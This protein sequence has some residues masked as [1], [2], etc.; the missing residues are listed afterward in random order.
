VALITSEDEFTYFF[1]CFQ[2]YSLFFPTT[3]LFRMNSVSSLLDLP[4]VLLEKL[5]KLE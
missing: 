2:F 5:N 3:T 4:V 1:K